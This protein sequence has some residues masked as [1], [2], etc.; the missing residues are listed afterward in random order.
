[1]LKNE[2]KPLRYYF[3]NEILKSKYSNE[4]ILGKV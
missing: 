4:K 2:C 1:M 3:P